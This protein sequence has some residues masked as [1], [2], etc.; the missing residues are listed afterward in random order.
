MNSDFCVKSNWKNFYPKERLIKSYI[1][2]KSECI[3]I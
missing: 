3:N 2:L 1:L